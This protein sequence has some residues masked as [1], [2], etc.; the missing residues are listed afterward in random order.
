MTQKF[1]GVYSQH[2]EKKKSVWRSIKT[3]NLLLISTIVVGS[4]Y[5]VTGINDLV[6]KGFE[7]RE[8]KM[9]V[10]H[11]SEEN[12]KANVET[13]TLKSYNNVAKRIEKLNMVAVDN[14]DYIKAESG[15][16]LVR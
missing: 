12:K 14:I 7:L 16:A 10:S 9:Q 1:E 4:L 15:V 6:V 2:I 8:L 13:M 5:Y 3:L 11:L